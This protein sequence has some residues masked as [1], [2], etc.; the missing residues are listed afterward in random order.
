MIPG[1]S[2]LVYLL[3]SSIC[4]IALY[5]V[6]KLFLGRT[7]YLMAN[8]IY[9]VFSI[10]FSIIIPLLNFSQEIEP[11]SGIYEIGLST[12]TV[13]AAGIGENIEKTLSSDEIIMI[14]YL[15]GCFLFLIK[16][17]FQ[18]LSF[19]RLVSSSEVQ[20]RDGLRFVNVEGN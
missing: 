16:F 4:L 11:V 1:N 13:G 10:I 12:I 15:A 14:I 6:Y 5:G 8:R 7:N 18:L 3:E 17:I 19:F 2:F 9:L 20:K